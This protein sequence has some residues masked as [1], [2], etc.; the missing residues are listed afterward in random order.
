MAKNCLFLA[1]P[2]EISRHSCEGDGH[3]EFLMRKRNHLG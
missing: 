3:A 1:L 2:S